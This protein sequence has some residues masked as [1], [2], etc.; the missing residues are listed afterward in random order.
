MY[1]LFLYLPV[2]FIETRIELRDRKNKMG[3]VNTRQ[4][5]IK[6]EYDMIMKNLDIDNYTLSKI[7]E[8]TGDVAAAL[9]AAEA[10]AKGAPLP[11]EASA[12]LMAP[13]PAFSTASQTASS[14][15]TTA[16]AT[17]T[18]T[19]PSSSSNIASSSSSA[20]AQTGPKP[21]RVFRIRA[22]D[23]S[24]RTS[25]EQQQQEGQGKDK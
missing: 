16:T 25:I 11:P 15:T 2:K 21:K 19:A 18:T 8:P 23:D 4:H 7:P 10:Q 20:A 1:Y 24:I 13:F 17:G 22:T 14:N 5:T 12:A 6:E 9:A 3:V